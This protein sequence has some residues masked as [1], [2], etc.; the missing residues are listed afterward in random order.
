MKAIKHKLIQI[1]EKVYALEIPSGFDLAMTFL[2]FQEY[3]ESGSTKFRGKDFDI[4]DYIKWYSTERPGATGQ[5]SYV[6]DWAGFNLPIKTIEECMD[7]QTSTPTP[8]DEFMDE[9]LHKIYNKFGASAEDSYLIGVPSVSSNYFE[10]ELS[11]ALW[12]TN[13]EYKAEMEGLVKGTDSEL[14]EEAYAKL[15]KMGYAKKVLKDEFVAYMSTGDH[16]RLIRSK[17]VTTL[18]LAYRAMF[19]IYLT[20]T[21]KY[22]KLQKKAA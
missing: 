4:W 19:Q 22:R 12:Y 16:D 17:D 13:P 3:Y 8:Y 18:S 9:I 5:F 20:R 7:R 1:N 10:H 15:Q 6:I 2:R 21:T 14:V 11:H